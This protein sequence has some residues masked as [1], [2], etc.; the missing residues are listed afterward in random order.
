MK[1]LSLTAMDYSVLFVVV[2]VIVVI[3]LFKSF[4]WLI[5][6]LWFCHIFGFYEMTTQQ[7]TKRRAFQEKL[8]SVKFLWLK[9]KLKALPPMIFFV[10]N[11]VIIPSILN[12][13]VELFVF[14]HVF[15]VTLPH[16]TWFD[17]AWHTYIGI[18]DLAWCEIHKSWKLLLVARNI[19]S[20]VYWK[21]IP[22]DMIE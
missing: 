5:K 20:Y 11:F 4:M 14:F 21:Y 3:I 13:V 22:L 18:F 10:L 2:V 1:T 15:W 7:M 8:D 6:F 12:V 9:W 16:F 17:F 19:I